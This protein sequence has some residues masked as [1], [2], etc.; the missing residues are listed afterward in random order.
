MEWQVCWLSCIPGTRARAQ[1]RLG[2]QRQR[3]HH[4]LD[5]IREAKPTIVVDVPDQ[6][7]MFTEEFIREINKHTERPSFPYFLTPPTPS[8]QRQ[9]TLWRGPKGELL[10]PRAALARRCKRRARLPPSPNATTVTSSPARVSASS[11]LR[12]HERAVISS[13]RRGLLRAPHNALADPTASLLPPL[14]EARDVSRK[15]TIAVGALA[16]KEGFANVC[17]DSELIVHTDEDT[18][19]PVYKIL[20]LK[21][22]ERKAIWQSI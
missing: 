7:G 14:N 6:P 12:Q 17:S 16:P 13:C 9:R 10:L 19:G 2:H 21:F 5:G 3:R 18:R 1:C 15:I 22:Q 11:P 8:K 4:L 20:K